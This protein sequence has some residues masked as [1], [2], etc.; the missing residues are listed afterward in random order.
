M[1]FSS[2]PFFTVLL[3]PPLTLGGLGCCRYPSA[4]AFKLRRPTRF[5]LLPPKSGRYQRI[6][7]GG[8]WNASTITLFAG[9]RQGWLPGGGRRNKWGLSTTLQRRSPLCA[10]TAIID[11][12]VLSLQGGK[13]RRSALV[14]GLAL[15][16]TNHNY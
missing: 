2:A 1:T 7:Q 10:V 3:C 9:C 13:R 12:G 5:W 14:P 11:P 16:H 4:R 15:G 6:S 8:G